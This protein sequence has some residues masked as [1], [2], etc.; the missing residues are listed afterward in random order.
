[1]KLKANFPLLACMLSFAYLLFVF[2]SE[3]TVLAADAVGGDPGGKVLPL[4]MALFMTLGFG[5]LTLQ[6]NCQI[7]S[8]KLVNKYFLITLFVTLLYLF[9]LKIVGFIIATS[10]LLYTLEY[11]YASIELFNFK[12]F[13]SGLLLTTLVTSVTYV[14]M[15]VLTKTIFNL[16]R[17]AYIPSFFA[18][19]S[20]QAII[21]LCFVIIATLI[22]KVTLCRRLRRCELNVIANSLLITFACVLLVYVV[23]KQFFNVNLAVGILNF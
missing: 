21:S 22:I 23:F 1:M 13:I 16:V 2:A 14:L 19:G 12:R 11:L 8:D 4:I 9:S 3:D 20:V 15:R 5:Y 6:G 17:L 18:I 10:C 7:K